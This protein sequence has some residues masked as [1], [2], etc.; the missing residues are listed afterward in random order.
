M[1][2]GPSFHFT[3]P[4]SLSQGEV[5]EENV[6]LLYIADFTLHLLTH[7]LGVHHH[8]T[9]G[10]GCVASQGIEQCGLTRPYGGGGREGGRV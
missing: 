3:D 8:L 4:Q 2:G 9:T 6:S 1:W 10:E 7:L 5:G